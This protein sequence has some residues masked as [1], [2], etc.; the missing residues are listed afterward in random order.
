MQWQLVPVD[1]PALHSNHQTGG[2]NA[3]AAAAVVYK[4]EGA[5][6]ASMST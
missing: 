4:P 2:H 3:A 6:A 5:A 1:K